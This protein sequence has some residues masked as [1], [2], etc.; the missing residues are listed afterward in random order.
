MIF[1]SLSF[2]EATARVS[3]D[4]LKELN[5]RRYLGLDQPEVRDPAAGNN[6]D[7]DKVIQAMKPMALFYG[8]YAHPDFR[9]ESPPGNSNTSFTN[10]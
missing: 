9:I 10:A 2:R 8:C 3:R 7:H 5:N 6:S 4:G 1:P